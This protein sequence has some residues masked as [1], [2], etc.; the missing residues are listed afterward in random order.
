M[1]L[2]FIQDIKCP[3]C[4]HSFDRDQYKP[5]II[6]EDKHVLCQI[7]VIKSNLFSKCPVCKHKP[8]LFNDAKVS[9]NLYRQLPKVNNEQYPPEVDP[10]V[11][12]K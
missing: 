3:Y 6:C 2:D 9:M 7:C 12:K 5:L 8:I 11:F 10:H 1:E 4:R